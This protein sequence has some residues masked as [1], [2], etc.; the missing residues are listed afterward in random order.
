MSDTLYVTTVFYK[1]N[2]N[3]LAEIDSVSHFEIKEY[4]DQDYE[5]PTRNKNHENGKG[6]HK[7]GH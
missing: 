5:K 7:Q 2:S 6:E 4:D 1:E 3:S